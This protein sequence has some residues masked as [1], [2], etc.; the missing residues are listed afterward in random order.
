MTR[1]M[2]LTFFTI[3]PAIPDFP[4]NSAMQVEVYTNGPVSSLESLQRPTWGGWSS[5]NFFRSHLNTQRVHTDD[6]TKEEN[7]VDQDR[8][9]PFCGG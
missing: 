8:P 4:N 1:P 6:K 7:T 5:M 9:G 2:G 3:D